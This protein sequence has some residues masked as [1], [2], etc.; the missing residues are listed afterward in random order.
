MKFEDEFNRLVGTIFSDFNV[1]VSDFK[2][3]RA[4]IASEKELFNQQVEL[5][6]KE[7]ID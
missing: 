1:C 7:F 6:V 4:V 5:F 2:D 3:Y